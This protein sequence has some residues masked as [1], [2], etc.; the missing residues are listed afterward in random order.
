MSICV[1]QADTGAAIEAIL[2]TLRILAADRHKVLSCLRRGELGEAAV[3]AGRVVAICSHLPVIVV[4]LVLQAASRWP[5][6]YSRSTCVWVGLSTS[7]RLCYFGSTPGRSSTTEI[8][9]IEGDGGK[10][11][12]D[13]AREAELEAMLKVL[14]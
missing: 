7:C 9:S 6:S 10:L 12:F 3:A 14:S 11:W 5:S 4:Y 13:V 8:H 1:S 2:P